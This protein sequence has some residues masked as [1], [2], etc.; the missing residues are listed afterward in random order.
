MFGNRRRTTKRRLLDVNEDGRASS[1]LRVN[2][3]VDEQRRIRSFR[4][5]AGVMAAVVITGSAVVGWLTLQQV[6][7]VLFS[8]NPRY[9]LRSIEVH[10]DGK[11]ITPDLFREWT[12]V[13]P[14]M[15]LFAVDILQIQKFVLQKA[16]MIK[17]IEILRHLPDRMEVRLSERMPV[18]RVECRG[19]VY[20]GIDREGHLFGIRGGAQTLPAIIGGSTV[21]LRSG[22]VAS[23]T[24]QRAL[25]VID[26]C[27]RSGVSRN[28]KIAFIDVSAEDMLSVY[29]A[30]GEN[31]RFPARGGGTSRQGLER[32]L[33]SLMQSIESAAARGRRIAWIDLTFNDDYIPAQEY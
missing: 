19:A 8:N 9:V 10:S 18:A 13:Q 22:T 30:S 12:G 24:I 15:N 7:R 32:K 3:R 25:E 4:I 6:G 31:V 17:S 33:Q 16:H 2:A 20:L 11:R 26:A 23:A 1:L 5:A 27:N 28:L 14:G 29:L 21:G